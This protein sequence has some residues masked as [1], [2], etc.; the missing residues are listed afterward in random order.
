[1]ILRVVRCGYHHRRVAATVGIHRATL[2]RWLASDPDF[3]EQFAKAWEDG[4]ERR[5]FLRW[6]NHPFRGFRPPADRCTRNF[7][8]Y[9]HPRIIRGQMK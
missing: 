7:P 8:R 4:A 2:Y 5:D 1:M 9:G 6:F 3:G